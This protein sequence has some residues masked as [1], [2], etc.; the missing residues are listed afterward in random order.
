MKKIINLKR[1]IFEEKISEIDE[2]SIFK[3]LE[4]IVLELELKIDNLDI[5]TPL[6]EYQKGSYI[7]QVSLNK[8]SILL[9]IIFKMNA[10]EIEIRP[11]ENNSANM[12]DIKTFFVNNIEDFKNQ[13]LEFIFTV[14][15]KYKKIKLYRYDNPDLVSEFENIYKELFQK[16][17][18]E[19]ISSI[20]LQEDSN[21]EAKF[22]ITAA[23][24]KNRY[25]TFNILIYHPSIRFRITLISEFLD[26]KFS[27]GVIY[28]KNYKYDFKEA[29]DL[30]LKNLKEQYK[31]FE[32]NS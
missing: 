31:F 23:D 26:T 14:F 25:V 28:L 19:I 15:N 5:I 12:S 6:S 20:K 24:S 9:D 2:N 32:N 16:H 21:S 10:L 18:F 27:S 13:A 7:L 17:G 29:L 3:I 8:G 30:E 1:F 4:E 22:I 11:T